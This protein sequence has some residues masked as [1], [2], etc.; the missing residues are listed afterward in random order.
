MARDDF[1]SHSGSAVIQ[2]GDTFV[3]SGGVN[4]SLGTLANNQRVVIGPFHASVDA[5][6][7]TTAMFLMG[8]ATVTEFIAP[9]A[10]DLIGISF[11]ADSSC[12]TGHGTITAYVGATASTTA[13]LDYS[14]ATA[15]TRTGYDWTPAG[16]GSFAAGAI[17]KVK[18][19]TA[20]LNTHTLT[21]NLFAN[22]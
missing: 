22:M 13:V 14:T 11:Y 5:T 16:A 19:K 2:A 3:G 12:T 20:S 1:L 15:E 18:V 8:S 9:A 7:G 4:A 6:A 17:I 21:V 10:G